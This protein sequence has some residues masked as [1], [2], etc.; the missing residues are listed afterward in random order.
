MPNPWKWYIVTIVEWD[1][2]PALTGYDSWYRGCG[3]HAFDADRGTGILLFTP[4]SYTAGGT[5][6]RPLRHGFFIAGNTRDEM[7]EYDRHLRNVFKTG[8]QP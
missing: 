2:H 7:W 8:H 6:Y 3:S 1:W 4:F 5:E